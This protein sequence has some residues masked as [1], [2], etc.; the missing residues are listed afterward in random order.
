MASEHDG[1]GKQ[2]K[3]EG[4]VTN[5]EGGIPAPLGCWSAPQH[6]EPKIPKYTLARMQLALY[7]RFCMPFPYDKRP[8]GMEA[9]CKH[10]NQR[11]A[12]WAMRGRWRD[13]EAMIWT[14]AA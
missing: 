3:H 4:G 9:T 6:E 1:F 7:G 12:L 14:R 10:K 5:D 8:I 13:P 2:E 11:A